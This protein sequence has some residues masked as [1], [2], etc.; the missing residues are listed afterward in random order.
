[1]KYLKGFNE[2]SDVENYKPSDLSLLHK[3]ELFLGDITQVNLAVCC[4]DCNAD[5]GV[6]PFYEYLRYVNPRYSK[7]K[8]IF[9]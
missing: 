7:I 5:R 2:S 4:R 8:H 6:I 3:E 1:M 9:V